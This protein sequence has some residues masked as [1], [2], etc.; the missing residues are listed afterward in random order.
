M[1]DLKLK[2]NS[3]FQFDLEL[4]DSDIASES[5]LETAVIISLFTDKRVNDERGFFGDSLE[6]EPWGSK[7]WTLQ[8]EKLTD[9]TKKK[10]E[11][12]AK[13]SLQWLI[14]DKIAKKITVESEIVKPARINLLVKIYKGDSVSDH[15]FD[16]IWG[17]Q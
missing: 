4:G 1:I 6:S 8:R 16:N 9:Q 14:D 2:A 5:A 7:I 10:L 13:E 11:D 17:E 3:S 12:Y 15:R